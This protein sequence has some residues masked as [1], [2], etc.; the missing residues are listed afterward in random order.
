MRKPI[1]FCTIALTFVLLST[2]IF[3]AGCTCLM[4]SPM[5]YGPKV[6]GDGTGGA[7]AVYEDIRGGNQHDFY[8][9]RISPTGDTL[10]GETGVL[11]GSG[12]KDSDSFFDLH[13]VND[14]SGGAFAV[15]SA[16]TS[17]PDWR[18]APG[19]RQIPYLTHLT[20]VGLEGNMLWQ[21][22]IG[23]IYHMISDGSGGVI[24]ASISE[25]QQLNILKVD[26]EGNYPWGEDGVQLYFGNYSSSLHMTGDGSGGAIIVQQ[27]LTQ[28]ATNFEIFVQ[29]V[30]SDGSLPWE[31]KGIH[32]YPP[33]G[34][35]EEVRII[36]DGSGG[37]IVA[38]QVESKDIRVQRVDANGNVL[39]Q[40]DGLPLELNKVAEGPF[41]HT[42]LLVSDR[43][44]GA[45][46]I[47]E[48]LRRGLASIY[49]QKVDADGNIKWQP[50]GEE[51]CYIKTNSS[52]WPRTAVSDGSGGVIIACSYK[53]AETNKKGLLAQKLDPAGRVVWDNGV[54]VTE[55]D[56][57]T[58][59]ISSDGQGGAIV[60]WGSRKSMFKSG[61]SY[62]QRIDSN[63]KLLWGTEGI[64]LNE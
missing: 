20:R 27:N 40:Q 46:V 34:N 15:W 32:L 51:V 45:I 50:S 56:H 52:F 25:E 57:I 62:V 54:V 21:R 41:L 17:E 61:R 30:S 28:T 3:S 24:I 19:Q 42:P 47:W 14:G 5:P 16:Y 9:Q 29:K 18:A 8:A 33:W 48:D 7:T 63:G 1:R 12:Y 26:S 13:I 31:Q 37:A 39:W 4:P 49:A 22:E 6:T 59:V 44:G 53:E 43:T 38:W 23:A 58:H 55:S 2:T 36:N 11:I 60:A 64:K 10:W 35:A